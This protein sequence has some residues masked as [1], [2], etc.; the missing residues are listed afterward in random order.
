MN[1]NLGINGNSANSPVGTTISN[2]YS[3]L[4][5]FYN[6]IGW[7]DLVGCYNKGTPSFNGGNPTFPEYWKNN[8]HDQSVH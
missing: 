5:N 8:G 7:S 6:D 4:V 2:I 3:G 1:T